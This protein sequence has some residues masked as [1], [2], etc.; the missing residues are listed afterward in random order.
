MACILFFSQILQ[1]EWYTKV[2]PWSSLIVQSCLRSGWCR[3][4]PPTT[5]ERRLELEPAERFSRTDGQAQLNNLC[6][7]FWPQI[8]TEQN[9]P[10]SYVLRHRVQHPRVAVYEAT[11]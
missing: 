10:P 4:I 7:W 11:N 3:F 6:R 2:H 9:T 1:Y 5:Q 8:Y